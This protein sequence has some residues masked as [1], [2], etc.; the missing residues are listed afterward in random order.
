VRSKFSARPSAGP[1]VSALP[2]GDPLRRGA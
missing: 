2:A 1:G